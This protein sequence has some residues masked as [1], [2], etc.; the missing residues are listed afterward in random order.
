MIELIRHADCPAC[1]AVEAALQE[2][3]IAHRVVI[4]PAGQTDDDLPLPALRDNDRLITGPEVAAYLRELE[5]FVA[6]W[7]KFQG[8]ACY[9]DDDGEVC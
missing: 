3:V 7:R 9:I 2:L 4:V 8:D 1:E 5:K 6:D